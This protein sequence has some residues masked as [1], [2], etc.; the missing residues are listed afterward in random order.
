MLMYTSADGT[1]SDPSRCR[2]KENSVTCSFVM[3]LIDNMGDSNDPKARAKGRALKNIL[4]GSQWKVASGVHSNANYKANYN[5]RI[6]L[7]IGNAPAGH[8]YVQEI[9]GAPV[10]DGNRPLLLQQWKGVT[11]EDHYY[12]IGELENLL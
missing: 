11:K 4:V 10:R 5:R 7:K 8:M 9:G 6:T 1:A 2:C 3:E 12:V